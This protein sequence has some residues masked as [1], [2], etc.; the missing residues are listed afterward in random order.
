VLASRA[1]TV[2]GYNLPAVERRILEANGINDVQE[3]FP[4]D[5]KGNPVIQPPQ[6]PELEFQREELRLKA[7]EMQDKAKQAAADISIKAML[8]EAQVELIQAQ[9]IKA[10]ADAG[11]VD[12]K[13]TNDAKLTA[14][15]ALDVKRQA[16]KDMQDGKREDRADSADRGMAK[17]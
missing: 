9:T 5:P 6:N 3:I 8:A 17:K 10:Y 1:A 13:A 15:K 2:P 7:L 4:M 12:E 14:I 16:L 11:A